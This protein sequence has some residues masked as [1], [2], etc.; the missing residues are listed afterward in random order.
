MTAI[1]PQSDNIKYA[2][3]LTEE[4]LKTHK[5]MNWKAWYDKG[6]KE[7]IFPYTKAIELLKAHL[8]ML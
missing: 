3:E 4:Y 5:R 8:T 7:R 1:V 2:R 6:L